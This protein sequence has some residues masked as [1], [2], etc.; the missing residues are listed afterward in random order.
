M[1]ATR[2][3]SSQLG[4]IVVC[5]TRTG[6]SS[7]IGELISTSAPPSDVSRGSGRPYTARRNTALNANSPMK[8]VTIEIA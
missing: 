1:A 5:T 4:A 3:T 2:P 8:I 7:C 6:L